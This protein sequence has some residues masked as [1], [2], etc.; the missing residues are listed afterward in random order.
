[1]VI[2]IGAIILVGLNGTLV[3]QISGKEPLRVTPQNPWYVTDE[4]GKVKYLTGSHTWFNIQ[5][6]GASNP[7]LNDGRK[8]IINDT[9]HLWG[10]GVDHQWVWK[11][12]LW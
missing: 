5:D 10:I 11:S 1:L 2:G 3:Q 8:I 4:S 7:P 12:F 9:D 6:R